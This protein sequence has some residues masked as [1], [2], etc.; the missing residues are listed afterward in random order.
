MKPHFHKVPIPEESTFNIRY[1]IKPDF[2]TIWHYHPELELHYVVKGEGVRIIGES[3]NNFSN[4]EVIL[5]GENLP[6]QWHCKKEFLEENNYAGVEAIVIQFQANFL[7]EKIL[8]MEDSSEL[9]HLYEKAKRGLLIKGKTRNLITALMTESTKAK[10]LDKIT[11]LLTILNILSE[12][13]EYEFITSTPNFCCFSEYETE[14]INRVSEFTL[15]NYSKQITLDEVASISNLTTTSFCRYFKLMTNKTYNDFL[16][17]VRINQACRF[18]I[19]D[20]QTI[21]QIS[22]RCGFNT[23]SNFYK[24]FKKIKGTSPQNFKKLFF[25]SE[26]EEPDFAS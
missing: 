25:T 16:C 8:S 24:Q 19:N 20:K 21:N 5:L 26:P 10:K 15:L 4:G 7:G 22:D 13:S 12:S 3:V 11:K 17:E 18:L 14:R 1:D 6:H 2:G 9:K 23:L